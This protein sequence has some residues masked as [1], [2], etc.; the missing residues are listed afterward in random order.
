[1]QTANSAGLSLEQW[2]EGPRLAVPGPHGCPPGTRPFSLAPAS[3][4]SV[5]V[6]ANTPVLLSST[7]SA[8]LV[9]DDP[10]IDIKS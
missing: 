6:L 2:E 10:G 4:S 7:P 5:A 3:P 9:R 1:M 8:Q